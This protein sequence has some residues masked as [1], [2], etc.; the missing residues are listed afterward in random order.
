MSNKKFLVCNH[1]GNIIEYTKDCG[2]PVMCCGEKMKEIMR[3][4]TERR[5]YFDK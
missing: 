2:V 1:C 5:K 3:L 4:S